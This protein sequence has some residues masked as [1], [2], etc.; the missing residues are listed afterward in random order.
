MNF[1]T[2]NFKLGAVTV[3][4]ASKRDAVAQACNEY[5]SRNGFPSTFDVTGHYK[6]LVVNNAKVGDRLVLA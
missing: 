5:R 2:V 4:A 1:Y 3:F 6:G